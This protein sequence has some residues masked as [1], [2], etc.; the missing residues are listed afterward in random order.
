MGATSENLFRQEIEGASEMK[1]HQQ[2][3]IENFAMTEIANVNGSAPQ[4]DAKR[5]RRWTWTLT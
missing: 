3:V 4:L 1:V 2:L 5:L